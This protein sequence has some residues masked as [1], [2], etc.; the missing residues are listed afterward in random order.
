MQ[1]SLFHDGRN[2]SVSEKTRLEGA[3][4]PQAENTAPQKCEADFRLDVP[5]IVGV[6]LSASSLI[7]VASSFI[8]RNAEDPEQANTS[9]LKLLC[10][11]LRICFS[12]LF[13][14]MLL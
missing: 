11:V 7:F 5:Y 9:A 4:S 13:L 12:Y 2:R 3:T 6:R 1:P 14:L 8:T 10:S